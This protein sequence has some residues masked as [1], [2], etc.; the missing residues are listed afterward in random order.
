MK[1]ELKIKDHFLSKE[2]FIVSKC[3]DGVLKTSPD[4]NEKTLFKYYDSDDY[5]LT[6]IGE[7]EL[8]F[9]IRFFQN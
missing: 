6:T 9:S 8:H 1:T 5:I 3:E 2:D 7:E 4:M